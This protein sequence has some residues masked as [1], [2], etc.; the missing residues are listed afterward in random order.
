[1]K[2]ARMFTVEWSRL[3]VGSVFAGIALLFMLLDF[4]KCSREHYAEKYG[5]KS[6]SLW[7]L[8]AAPFALVAIIFFDGSIHH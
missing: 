7:M 8:L 2:V 4:R 1:M 5:N 3:A 6:S